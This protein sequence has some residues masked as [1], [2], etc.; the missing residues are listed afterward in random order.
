MPRGLQVAHSPPRSPAF[1]LPPSVLF[2]EVSEERPLRGAPNH[3][4]QK[5]IWCFHLGEKN[6][7]SVL[8]GD[9]GDVVV[10]GS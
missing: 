10:G 2:P 4:P 5:L 7:P 6:V 8:L 1:P 3:S 9:G